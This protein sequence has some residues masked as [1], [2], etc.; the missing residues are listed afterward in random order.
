M[1]AF[2]GNRDGDENLLVRARERDL[3]ERE[4]RELQ[5]ALESN[6]TLRVAYRVGKAFDQLSTVKTGDD[7]LIATATVNFAIINGT[8]PTAGLRADS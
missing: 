3:S 5:R 4:R 6:V 2:G 1:S 8:T 7:E